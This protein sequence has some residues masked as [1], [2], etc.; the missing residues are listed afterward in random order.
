MSGCV[1]EL[2]LEAALDGRLDPAATRQV[3]AHARGCARCREARAELEALAQTMRA[4]PTVVPDDLRA[5]RVRSAVQSAVRMGP[6]PRAGLSWPRSLAAAAVFL[7]LLVGVGVWSRRR[8]ATSGEVASPSRVARSRSTESVS[9]VSMARHID[10]EGAG[11]LWPDSDAQVI[12]RRAGA[13]TLIDLWQGRI[14]M[15]VNHRAPGER[16]VVNLTDG[17]VEVRGT[18]FSVRADGGR[19][20]RVDVTEGVVA[21]RRHGDTE[22]LLTAGSHFVLPTLAPNPPRV[23]QSQRD[24]PTTTSRSEPDPARWFR[25]G[26]LAYGRGEYASAERELAMFLTRSTHTDPRRE[27][28]RYLRVL[29]LQRLRRADETSHEVDLYLREFPQGVRRSEAVLV[30]VRALVT[31]G[32]CDDARATARTMPDDAA[33]RVQQA[34]AAALRC[35]SRRSSEGTDAGTGAVPSSAGGDG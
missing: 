18:R 25:R 35:Q 21:L 23:S 32:R 28:A 30:A 10:L 16:F 34:M 15:Q 27:D 33:P 3:L 7:V 19:L 22:R 13:E 11:T 9:E 4:M 8:G 17:E 14:T 12:V 5:R 29:S 24:V 1:R 26:S 2:E 31:A 6:T 20:Q